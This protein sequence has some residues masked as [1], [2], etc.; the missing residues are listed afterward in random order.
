MRLPSP[1]AALTFAAVTLA[2]AWGAL[3]ADQHMSG[4]ASALDWIEAPFTDWLF[5]LAGPR[6]APP[7]ILIVAI[8]D[9]TIR[10]VGHYP[11]PRSTVARLVEEIA[12]SKPKVIALDILFLD[13]GPPEAD[14]ALASALQQT[15]AVV[16]AAAVFAWDSETASAVDAPFGEVP[17][18]ERALWPVEAVRQVAGV[19][20]VNVAADHAGTPRHVPLIIQVDHVLHPSFPLRVTTAAAQANPQIFGR[21]RVQIGNHTV[22]IDLGFAL[23]LRFYGARGSVSTISAGQVLR[24]AVNPDRFHDRIV[25]IG[26]TAIGTGDMFSTPFDPVLPGVEVLATAIGHLST[27]SGLAR[28]HATRR[29]DAMAAVALPILALT[30]LGM[31]SIG[32][33]LALTAL[34]AAAWVSLTAFAFARGTWLS[35]T[36]PLAATLP[37]VALYA[38]AR[39]WLDQRIERRLEVARAAFRRFHPPALADRLETAP[40]FLDKP[41]QQQAAVV[42]IDLSSFT[43]LSER[44]GPVRTRDLLKEFHALVDKET[45]RRNGLVLNFMGDGAMMAFGLPEAKPDDAARALVTAQ[46]LMSK[47]EAWLATLSEAPTPSNLGLGVRLGV[48]YGPVV[49]S[50]LGGDTHQHITI[51]GDTVN[52]ASRL[53]EVAKAHRAVL[54]AS[55]DLLE[56]ARASACPPANGMETNVNIRGRVQP[57]AVCLWRSEPRLG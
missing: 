26:A 6:P 19:G 42:F 30:F 48:H 18:A 8:N 14:Q 28:T 43:G 57:L 56:A 44:I 29:F 4:R 38:A 27:D 17:V 46:A 21:D 1:R 5:L 13:P 32:I 49:V 25:V 15:H 53:L 24:G 39:L 37:P 50:R 11:L 55:A 22:Q 9:E 31:R 12:R 45:T 10:E 20:F 36:V 41:V 51:T 7:N 2:A 16:G 33:G 40:D 34:V 35:M 3:L 23:P 47:V 52:V 54:A